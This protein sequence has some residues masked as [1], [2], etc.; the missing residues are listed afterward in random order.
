MTV[1]RAL[2]V[3]ALLTACGGRSCG[4]GAERLATDDG[5]DD[6]PEEAGARLEAEGLAGERCRFEGGTVSLDVNGAPL[7][8]GR[9]D[10]DT[11]TS[12]VLGVTSRGAA[13][14]VFGEVRGGADAESALAVTR[15]VP[16]GAIA[17]DA[18]PPRVFA[19]NAG[20]FAL[21]HRASAPDAGR[22]PRRR[23]ALATV[24]RGATAVR[25]FVDLPEESLDESLAF[26]AAFHDDE[27]GSALVAWDDD[28]GD[29][30]VIR[31]ASYQH[32][33]MSE[34]LTVSRKSGDAS[35]PRVVLRSDGYWVFWSVRKE[36]T[37]A[38]G[39]AKLAT[40]EIEG[41]GELRAATWI[42]GLRIGADGKPLGAPFAVTSERGHVGVFDVLGGGPSDR[43][44]ASEAHLYLR[45]AERK[46][47]LVHVTVR[48]DTTTAPAVQELEA[49]PAAIEGATVVRWSEGRWLLGYEDTTGRSLMVVLGGSTGAPPAGSR[50]SV[51]SVAGAVWGLAGARLLVA[52]EGGRTLRVATCG[53]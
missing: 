7:E 10:G 8:L 42:E 9:A 23:L 28:E 26:D 53:R 13:E 25:S 2:F 4:C 21:F 24:E 50:P 49:P 5:G 34:T 36:E 52:T 38:D 20:T 47:K 40:D 18:P 41:A 32:G 44:G 12:F 48:D 33:T 1:R 11:D 43:V 14:L 19:R 31:V 51:E 30:G 29:R 37:S 35:A 6:D 45:D 46:G 22:L 16:L 17:G 27:G 15:R 3:L 39:G